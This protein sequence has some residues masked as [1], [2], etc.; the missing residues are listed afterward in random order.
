MA[1]KQPTT[2][3][4]ATTSMGTKVGYINPKRKF[5]ILE[6]SDGERYTVFALIIFAVTDEEFQT[7]ERRDYIVRASGAAG[8]AITDAFPDGPQ[9]VA[10]EKLLITVEVADETIHGYKGTEKWVNE[11]Q[12]DT[13]SVTLMG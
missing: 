12:I 3:A 5:R 6:D 1:I 8:K 13:R 4:A 9:G 7:V 11:I 2:P 10:K